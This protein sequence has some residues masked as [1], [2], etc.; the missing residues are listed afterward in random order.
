M[1]SASGANFANGEDDGS[2]GARELITMFAVEVGDRCN[3]RA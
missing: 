2:G 3:V 1:T